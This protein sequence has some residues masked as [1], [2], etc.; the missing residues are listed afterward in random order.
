MATTVGAASLEPKNQLL[1][2]FPVILQNWMWYQSTV[3]ASTCVY[4]LF[5]SCLFI[6]FDC[7]LECFDVN[8]PKQFKLQKQIK[9]I[10]RP[11]NLIGWNRIIS[12]VFY[13]HGNVGCN[14]WIKYGRSQASRRIGASWKQC[15]QTSLFPEIFSCNT[16]QRLKAAIIEPYIERGDILTIIGVLGFDFRPRLRIFSLPPRPERFWSPPS[17]Y[18]GLFPWGVKRPGREADHSPPSSAG[19]KEWVELYLCSP[20]TPSWRGAHL[21]H[22]DNFT[23][24]LYQLS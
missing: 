2:T 23:F 3:P 10:Q 4:F 17:F 6:C 19:V 15:L 1:G 24:Y 20:N 13:E 9:Q 5:G 11:W 7:P 16:R 14:V 18:Q 22:R 21:K 8:K 12:V